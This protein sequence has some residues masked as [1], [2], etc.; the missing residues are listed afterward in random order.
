MTYTRALTLFLLATASTIGCGRQE[1][2][3]P[4]AGA[5]FRLHSEPKGAISVS[6]LKSTADSEVA[7]AGCIGGES[8]PW[9]DG[10]AAFMLA[11]ET[12]LAHCRA[13]TGDKNCQCQ[14]KGLNEATVLVKFVDATGEPLPVDSRKL[15]RVNE[16]DRVVVKGKAER[17]ADGNVVI[18]AGGIFVRR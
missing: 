5:Q 8:N 12:V 14:A 10:M 16:L 15:L 9:V 4:S 18:V 17:D 13:E 7:V 11:D 3:Q 1:T 2:P 6:Q